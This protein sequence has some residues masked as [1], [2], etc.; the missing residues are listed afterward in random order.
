VDPVVAAV[1]FIQV[2]QE[3]LEAQVI[4]HQFLRHKD[5]QVAQVVLLLMAALA[6]AAALVVQEQTVPLL[7][8]DPVVSVYKL[9]LLLGILNPA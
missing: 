7:T 9:P 6:A 5:H 1:D 8:E 2:K 4:H 3:L